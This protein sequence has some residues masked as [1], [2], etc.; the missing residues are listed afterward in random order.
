MKKLKTKP[1]FWVTSN[2]YEKEN[3]FSG[4]MKQKPI[5]SL[6]RTNFRKIPISLQNYP[7]KRTTLT[8]IFRILKLILH[9][10][11]Q[12]F[13]LLKIQHFSNYECKRWNGMH[14]IYLLLDLVLIFF[15]THFK[16]ILQILRHV[17]IVLHSSF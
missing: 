13:Y 6:H 11:A 1:T 16:E 12:F 2:N 5:F 8:S 3:Q 14:N 4:Y 10:N 7:F 9:M 17:W 15:K